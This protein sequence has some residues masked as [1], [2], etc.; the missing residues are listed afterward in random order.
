MIT[1][2]KTR[3]KKRVALIFVGLL[4]IGAAILTFQLLA[5]RSTQVETRTSVQNSD[6]AES[7]DNVTPEEVTD[8][9]DNAKKPSD[10]TGNSSDDDQ[11][12]QPT[13]SVKPV[14]TFAEDRGQEIVVGAFVQSNRT[15]K[16]ILKLTK[17]PK[18]ISLEF[19]TV[20]QPT[21]YQ[22]GSN[23]MHVA[24]TQFPESGEWIATVEFVSANQNGISDPQSVEVR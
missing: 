10:S 17:G 2:N 18:S 4:I 9:T 12:G 15:G 5:N 22:C 14:I 23:N 16:C 3:T 11:S 8:T 21:S 19:S 20:A 7:A 13:S 6:Q 1:M 24:Q